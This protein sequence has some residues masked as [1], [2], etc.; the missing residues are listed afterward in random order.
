M[1]IAGLLLLA[2]LLPA[3]A[4]AALVNIN[5]AD[6]TL[7]DTLPGIGPAYATRIVE[8]RSAHGPFARIEDIQNVSGIG[9]STYAGLA[10]FITVGDTNATSATTT[11]DT[12]SSTLSV[13]SGGT[14][15]YVPPPSQLSV[16]VSGSQEAMLE[17]PL[18][19]SARVTSKSGAVDPSAQIIWSFGDGSSMSGNAVE[20][21]YRYAGTYLVIVDATD[22][23]ARARDELIVTV[24]PAQVRLLPVS[25]DGITVANDS[26]ER[27]D[28]SGWR[29]VSD[30]GMFRIPDGT[31]LLPEA[32]VLFPFIIT[33]LPIALDAV[34]L[35]PDGIVAAHSAPQPIVEAVTQLSAP[36][37]SSYGEQTVEEPSPASD[38]SV[39]GT[40]HEITAVGAP[41]AATELAAVG[42]TSPAETSS[43]GGTRI[44][45]LFRSP[46]TLG[47]LG[48][49]TL[50]GGAFILL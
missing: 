16:E 12:A 25:G 9:P 29:L 6:A 41:T 39:S 50:A 40:A 30:T 42:A 18:R 17:V 5:T 4:H 43:A 46:W 19:L 44:T 2:I 7:L 10:P 8:Y 32:S 28:L 27:L 13:S 24:K 45:S 23:T 11:A 33:D 3:L 47:F 34:L 48:L 14:T 21:V 31:T 38:I 1:R 20:K 26:N 15:T 35:Y 49:M 36:A 22:G 37:Q